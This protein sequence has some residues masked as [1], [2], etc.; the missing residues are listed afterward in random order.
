MHKWPVP[1]QLSRCLYEGPQDFCFQPLDDD[2][3]KQRWHMYGGGF[4]WSTTISPANMVTT[5]EDRNIVGLMQPEWIEMIGLLAE[6]AEKY[7][8][9]SV[10]N[11]MCIW[12]PKYALRLIL[13][14]WCE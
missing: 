4:V 2:R 11:L 1:E 14:V 7:E 9:T 6:G 12:M 3:P 13:A 8:N 5:E 10:H